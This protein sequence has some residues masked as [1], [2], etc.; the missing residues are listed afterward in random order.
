MTVQKNIRARY[1]D[2]G[3]R[4]SGVISQAAKALCVTVIAASLLV[5]GT[6]AVISSFS[7]PVLYIDAAAW[8][9]LAIASFAGGGAS[10][11]VS[12]ADY[13]RIS[14]ISG[15]MFVLLLLILSLVTGSAGSP[16]FMAAGYGVSVL[17]HC[18][19]AAAAN[20][21]FGGRRKRRAY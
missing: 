4:L 16:L 17:L 9:A 3:T 7:D 14:L 13:G 12:R 5:V 6:A 19:G 8:A 18:A 15:G 2:E 10:F 21:L 1:R 20:K 11:A